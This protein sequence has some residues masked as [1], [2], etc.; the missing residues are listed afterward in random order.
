MLHDCTCH[1]CKAVLGFIGPEASNSVQEDE[2]QGI[3]YSFSPASRMQPDIAS[4]LFLES[5]NV[6]GPHGAGLFGVSFA[7]IAEAAATGRRL[8]HALQV[9][10]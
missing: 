1:A 9:S 7:A 5:S 3:S 6:A 8:L 2:Q 10:A 4:G